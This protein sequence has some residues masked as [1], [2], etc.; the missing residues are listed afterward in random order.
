[1]NFDV[2]FEKRAVVAGLLKEYIRDKGYTKASLARRIDSSRI[3][4]DELLSGT[5]EDKSIFTKN[6]QKVLLVLG[7]TSDELLLGFHNS[8]VKKIGVTHLNIPAGYEMS[9]KA[10]RQYDL[11]MDVQNVLIPLF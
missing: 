1:M 6:L 4:L 10:K 11:L 8:Q 9:E 7:M 5:V 2:L 3:I